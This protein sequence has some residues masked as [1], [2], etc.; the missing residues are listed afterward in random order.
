[1]GLPG[2]VPPTQLSLE[3]SGHIIS[4]LHGAKTNQRFQLTLLEITE[5]ALLVYPSVRLFPS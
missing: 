4:L 5:L 1:M 2:Y 3:L